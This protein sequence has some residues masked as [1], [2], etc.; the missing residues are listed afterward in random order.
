MTDGTENI[1][2]YGKTER[3]KDIFILPPLFIDTG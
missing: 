1:S 2:K 3:R